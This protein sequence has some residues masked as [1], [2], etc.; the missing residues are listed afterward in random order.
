MSLL[1][2]L[3]AD[4]TVVC[5]THVLGRAYLFDQL[6]FVHGGHLI[7]SG[8]PDEALTWFKAQNGREEISLKVGS[9]ETRTGLDWRKEFEQS[10][11]HAK[12]LAY[13]P[14]AEG[15]E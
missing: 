1:R 11:V 13:L 14:S 9:D 8:T 4:C 15:D 10:R 12:P 2:R 5:T 3:A 7:F 6:C